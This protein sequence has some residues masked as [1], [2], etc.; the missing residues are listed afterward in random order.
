MFKEMNRKVKINDNAFVSA[1]RY[2]GCFDCEYV[3]GVVWLL[4]GTIA[5]LY[6]KHYNSLCNVEKRKYIEVIV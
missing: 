4:H 5:E 2:C 1:E 3:G 6:F